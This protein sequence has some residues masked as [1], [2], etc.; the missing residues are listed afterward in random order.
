[1]PIT[2]RPGTWTD[3][4]PMLSIEADNRG[5]ALIGV[6]AAIESWR[7]VVRYP[8][9][10]SAVIESYPAIGGYRILGLGASVLVSREFADAELLNP[11]PD[12]NSRIMA[13]IYADQSVLA[14]RNQV[15]RANTGEGVDIVVLAGSWRDEILH[16][17][18]RQAVQT[19]F[20]ESFTERHRGYRIKRILNETVSEPEK[21]F[22]QNSGVF[23]PIAEFPGLGRVLHLMTRDSAT[24]MPASLGNI[25]FNYREPSLHLRGSDQQLLLA[26]VGGATD[27]ELA[28]ELRVTLSAV[29]ARWRSIIS[30]V[31]ETLPGLVR[32][33]EDREGRGTQKRHR[34]L[35]YVRNHPEELQPFDWKKATDYDRTHRGVGRSKKRGLADAIREV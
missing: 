34:V 19:M 8:F 27:S 35:A 15:A 31:E 18:E 3:I 28:S 26:A 12:I 14:T 4:E 5:D 16:P 9:F 11:Q 29:K 6:K 22:V 7:I 17:A 33:V 30:R 25:L 32:H 1:M 24:T 13:S 20:A 10:A 2:W 21:E 23:S